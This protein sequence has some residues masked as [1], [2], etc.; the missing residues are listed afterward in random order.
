MHE[1][2]KSRAARRELK[3]AKQSSPT[4]RGQ[5]RWRVQIARHSYRRKCGRFET[6]LPHR[7]VGWR[8][9]PNPTLPEVLA[10]S[11]PPNSFGQ[12]R[13]KLPKSVAVGTS[14]NVLTLVSANVTPA[15]IAYAPARP[16]RLFT[17]SKSDKRIF[18]RSLLVPGSATWANLA[19][20]GLVAMGTLWGFVRFPLVPHQNRRRPAMKAL[21]SILTL[22]L[23]IAFSAPA[24]KS[25]SACEKAGMTWDATASAPKVKCN[26]A[27]A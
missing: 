12:V 14:F 3:P 11:L 25:Q 17:T 23:A 15:N 2:K 24:P 5:A 1:V 4:P 27:F 18:F 26:P 7:W 13:P 20:G 16:M 10:R 19:Q 21:V 8:E 6:A 22:I 9:A